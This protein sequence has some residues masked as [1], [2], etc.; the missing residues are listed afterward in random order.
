M[1]AGGT[2]I[3]IKNRLK[4]WQIQLPTTE[5]IEATGVEIECE[6]EHLRIIAVY[7]SPN[8][9]LIP[10]ELKAPTPPTLMMSDLNCKHI[11]LG[12]RYSNPNGNILRS[13]LSNENWIL[14]APGE[15]THFPRQQ[16]H[17][18][19]TLD[20]CL[21]KNFPF[22]LEQTTLSKLNSDHLPVLVTIRTSG[23]FE[24]L[25]LQPHYHRPI[26]MLLQ[27]HL[28]PLYVMCLQRTSYQSQNSQFRVN[29]AG[30]A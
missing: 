7:K 25:H 13:L 15:A 5:N 6:K 4:H 16:G 30:E 20:V 28:G 11:D 12:C 18:P 2:A 29:A 26:P 17:E 9:C 27:T 1:D 3:I 19:D 21:L 10:E 22:H 8:R 14:C 24:H 23:P